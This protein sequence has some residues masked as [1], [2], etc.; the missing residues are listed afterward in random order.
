MKKNTV[1]RMNVTYPQDCH[2]MMMKT[3]LMC[4]VGER[5]FKSAN[6]ETIEKKRQQQ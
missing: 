1:E 3:K 4:R 5:E 2:H 6:R